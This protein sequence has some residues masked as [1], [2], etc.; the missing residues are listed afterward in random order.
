MTERQLLD[1]VS[2]DF[3][4]VYYVEFNFGAKLQVTQ[5]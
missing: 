3:T 2:A 1:K 4:A 5:S